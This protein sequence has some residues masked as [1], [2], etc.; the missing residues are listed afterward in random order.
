MMEFPAS[1]GARLQGALSGCPFLRNI[2]EGSGGSFAAARVACSAGPVLEE[3]LDSL[4]NTYSLFHG[5][6]GVVP[7][8]DRPGRLS[9]APAGSSIAPLAS[10]SIPLLGFLPGPGDF[11]AKRARQ[12]RQRKRERQLPAGNPPGAPCATFG[13][14]RCR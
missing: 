5:R 14:R 12:R 10:F 13:R 6:E 1:L 4:E 11:W 3:Q 2:A 9:A 7:L 8:L